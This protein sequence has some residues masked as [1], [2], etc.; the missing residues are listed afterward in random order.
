MLHNRYYIGSVTYPGG[1]RR[2]APTAYLAGA[3]QQKV[4][5]I[6]R[7]M[8]SP[9]NDTEC[10]TTTLKVSLVVDLRGRYSNLP[11][12]NLRLRLMS[13]EW[14]QQIHDLHRLIRGASGGQLGEGDRLGPPKRSDS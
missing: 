7:P 4:Q 2:Q 13:P 14:C 10:I 1:A 9:A 8:T 12:S 11:N 6:S 3:V 5:Q